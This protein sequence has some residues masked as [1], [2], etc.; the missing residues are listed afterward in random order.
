MIEP[1][2]P[3]GAEG[4]GSVATR[5]VDQPQEGVGALDVGH[6]VLGALLPV[7]QVG[8][9][10]REGRVEGEVALDRAV[11]VPEVWVCGGGGVII[12]IYIFKKKKVSIVSIMNF[13]ITY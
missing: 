5:V 6:L 9:R 12:C 13:F 8:Q 1:A 10:P 3:A 2:L 4:C 7:H 11:V